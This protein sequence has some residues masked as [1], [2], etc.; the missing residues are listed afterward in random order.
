MIVEY[1]IENEE[2]I[3]IQGEGNCSKLKKG[4]LKT[5]KSLKI[6]VLGEQKHSVQ[7]TDRTESGCGHHS[8][9]ICIWK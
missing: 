4:K 1:N 6:T 7:S 5:K 8:I 3:L 9:F 2:R